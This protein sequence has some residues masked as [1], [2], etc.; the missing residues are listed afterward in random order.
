MVK[1][2]SYLNRLTERIAWSAPDS[3]RDRP[4]M[5]V[6]MGKR[7][8]LIVEAGASPA[9]AAQFRQALTELQAAPARY[10]ALTH[11]HWD[12]VFGT[13]EWGLPTFAQRETQRRVAEMARLDW[14]DAALQAR[15]AAGE[16]LPFI[17]DHLVQELTEPQRAALT[18]VTPDVIFD[19]S[20]EIDLG[21]VTCRLIHVGGDH[22]PDSSV[23]YVP[24]ER[25][26]FLGDCFYSGF[27]GQELFYTNGRLFPLLERLMQ[28]DADHYLLA[29]QPVPLSRA[30]FV[31]EAE[32]L[33]LIGTVV[34]QAEGNREEALERLNM[35]LDD[36]IP[37]DLNEYL[38]AFLRG[39]REDVAP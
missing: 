34:A 8:S 4:V 19:D 20:I 26:V 37:E 23:V 15:V 13:G 11:W 7:S 17:A 30:D 31:G 5:G 2:K 9:H 1:T 38:D 27:V 25:V 21:G 14:R 22:S 32:N 10:V 36:A 3:D 12:H 35:V 24:E 18:I 29:H 28:L 39:L 33:R 16:E 6:V